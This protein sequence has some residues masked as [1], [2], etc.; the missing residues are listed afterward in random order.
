MRGFQGT[1]LFDPTDGGQQL[2]RLDIRN[3]AF[4]KPRENVTFQPT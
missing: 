2:G 4:A 3:G 1:S